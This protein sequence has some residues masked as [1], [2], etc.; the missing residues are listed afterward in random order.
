MKAFC[1]V[2]SIRGVVTMTVLSFFVAPTI[3]IVTQLLIYNKNIEDPEVI[4]GALSFPAGQVSGM[5]RF[6][7]IRKLREF[8]VCNS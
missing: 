4:F 3:Y 2:K 5:L 6:T 8:L 1:G 7:A